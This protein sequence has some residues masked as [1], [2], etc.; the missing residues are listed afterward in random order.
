MRPADPDPSTPPR[1]DSEHDPAITVIMPVLN[2]IGMIERS[3]AALE[4]STLAA[5]LW[6]L[7]VVDD[8]STDGTAD[9][10]RAAGHRITA[11]P[12]GPRGPGVARNLGATDARGALLV[13]VDADVCV[14]DDVLERFH[15]LFETRPGLG[16]AFGAYDE[17]P[18]HPGFLS[19]YRNLYHRYVHLQGAGPAETFWA[20]CGAVRTEVF[21]QLG[22]FD[23]ERYPRPQIED[24]ELGY[25][26]RDAGWEIELDPAISSTHLK[27]WRLRGMLRTDL[28]DRGVP[29]MRLL[30]ERP[31]EDQLNVKSSE[32]LRTGLVGVACL[33]AAAG[34]FTMQPLIALLALVPL[35]V[36]ILSNLAVYR[37]FAARRGLWFAIRVVPFNIVFYF[38]SGMAV[39]LGVAA[40]VLSGP[41][42]PSTDSTNDASTSTPPVGSGQQPVTSSREIG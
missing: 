6:E 31:R 41:G 33:L 39:V 18:A 15:Q 12:G 28:F 40:H 21:R 3:I 20:G 36:L 14:H 42:S 23:V 35:A 34:V 24:I 25:R 30:L 32:R 10:V 2:G 38:I 19:Q 5:D 9:F 11:V 37:W 8:G 1:G 27:H 22:G 7:L 13:F 17:R 26:I 29:W 4:V 16:A